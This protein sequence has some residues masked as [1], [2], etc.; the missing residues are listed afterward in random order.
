MNLLKVDLQGG[1]VRLPDGSFV[2]ATGLLQSL[3][4]GAYTLGMRPHH[5]Y[6]ERPSD[7]ALEVMTEVSVTEITGSE[8]FVHV[9][10]SAERWVV[11]AHGV[12]DLAAGDRLAVHIDPGRLFVFGPDEQLVASPAMQAAA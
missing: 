12:Q 1:Q 4:E 11:L 7:S 5:L 10:Y 6:L 2:P 8:S 9:S 3:S